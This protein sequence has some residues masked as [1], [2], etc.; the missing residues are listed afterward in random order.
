MTVTENLNKN[1]ERYRKFLPN[2]CIGRILKNYILPNFVLKGSK[3][4]GIV[5]L[6]CRCQTTGWQLP[7]CRGC[8][9]CR[10]R[11]EPSSLPGC[12][13]RTGGWATRTCDYN[14][15]SHS[16]W[17]MGMAS[18]RATMRSLTRAGHHWLK[19]W[20]KRKSIADLWLNTNIRHNR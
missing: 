16:G 7:G 4:S 14:K 8:R 2:V 20:V 13:S 18:V 6:S 3:S 17:A 1:K 19:F 5:P 10:C 9:G 12:R 11:V 15:I